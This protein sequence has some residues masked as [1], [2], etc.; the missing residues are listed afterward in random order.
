M[1]TNVIEVDALAVDEHVSALSAIL[2]ASVSGGAAIGFMAPLQHNDAARYW[3]DDIRTE[4]TAKRRTLFAGVHDGRVVG[5]VQ[6]IIAMP[7][8]Q[9]HRCEIAKMMVHPKF[10]RLG[11]GRLLMEHAIKRA[12][13]L[14]KTLVTLDTRSGDIAESL[15][16]SLGFEV[17]GV[18]P[19]YAWDPDGRTRHSTI[20]M[21]RR[22]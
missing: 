7:P 14:G 12:G 4:V 5:T 3:S 18:I 6:L 22:I 10:R 17:A 1:N 2:V 9:P 13:E 20:Y 19:G 21:F 16:A 11:V 8:N 15:Y